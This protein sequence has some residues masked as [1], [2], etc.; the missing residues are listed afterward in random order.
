MSGLAVI[1]LIARFWKRANWQGALT[2]LIV[3]PSV[4][5]ALRFTGIEGGIWTPPIIPAT[6]AG[7]LAH[8]VVS[9]LTPASTSTFDATAAAM[10]R[11]RENIEGKETGPVPS[12]RPEGKRE[13]QRLPL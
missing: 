1:I 8:L 4:S 6:M 5:L 7:I 11:E 9:T 2:A 10:A 12:M 3:T 13:E